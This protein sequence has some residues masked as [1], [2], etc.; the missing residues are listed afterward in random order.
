MAGRWWQV[1]A[2]CGRE[3]R[4]ARGGLMAA[5]RRWDPRIRQMMPCPG[6][7]QLPVPQ[8]AEPARAMTG[9]S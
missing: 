4:L 7:G 9:V 5:H 2:G 3:R 8:A 6:G 1:C